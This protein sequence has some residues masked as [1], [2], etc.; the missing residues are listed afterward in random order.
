MSSLFLESRVVIIR[1]R[2][3]NVGR[4]DIN[5]LISRQQIAKPRPL[6]H[7]NTLSHNP[8]AIDLTYLHR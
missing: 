6:Q 7:V 8:T 3:S 5:S 2:H 1:V 4:D